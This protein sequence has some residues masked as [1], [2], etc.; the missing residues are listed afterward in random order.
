MSEDK[1]SRVR[2]L[3]KLMIRQLKIKHTD[4]Q[5]QVVL[6]DQAPEW[7]QQVIQTIQENDTLDEEIYLF[8]NQCLHSITTN[9][10][11]DDTIDSL[12]PDSYNKDLLRWLCSSILRAEYVNQA[13]EEYGFCSNKFDIF[14]ALQNAQM[15]EKFEVFSRLVN[16]LADLNIEC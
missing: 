7:M 5:D 13:V 2:V 15:I 3:A 4:N 14:I 16:A 9:V 11:L 12:K 8:L 6:K 1:F 10:S